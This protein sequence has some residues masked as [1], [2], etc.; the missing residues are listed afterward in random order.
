MEPDKKQLKVVIL[1]GSLAGLMCGIALKHAGHEVTI[2][3]KGENVRQSHMAGVCLGLDAERFLERHDRL[4]NVFSHRCL[5]IQAL[6][7]DETVQVFINARRDITNWDAYYFRLRANFDGYKSSF[8]PIPPQ[9]SATDGPSSYNARREVVD[10]TRTGDRGNT[11]LVLS[12]LD[13]DTRDVSKVEADLVVGADG[14]DSFIRAKYIPESKR[15]YV[16][17]IAWRGTVPESE[18]SEATRDVFK[19]SVTIHLMDRHHCLVYTIPGVDGS[20]EKGERYL[21]FLW[22]TNETPEALDEIL[23]DGID[24]HRHHNI[25]PSG[26]VRK[27]IW[28]ARLQTARSIPL[29]GP[30]LEIITKIERPFIQVITEVISPRA[31][32]EDGRVLLMGDGLS[33]YRPHTAFSGTQAAFHALKVEEYVEGKISAQ[34]YEEK[35]LR[36]AR[37]HWSQ[38]IWYGDFYQYSKWTALKSALYYWFHCGIDRVN[39]WWTGEE[40]LLRGWSKVVEQYDD[41]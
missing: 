7:S 33:L 29:P 38:S 19:R 6:K 28:E 41:E 23:I 11:K 1:G 26:H 18:V 12:V 40:R 30:F 31:S 14:P 34:E 21:N 17:Y 36:Y 5:R 9:P 3:E 4:S 39:S 27:D 15:R 8:Y 35:A 2:I 24:G 37:L 13:H 32:F 16:G 22:Y 25:V 20:L 10:L